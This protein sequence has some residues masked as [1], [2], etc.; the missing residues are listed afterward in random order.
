[1]TSVPGIG[2]KGAEILGMEKDGDSAI[3]NTYQLVGK[4][5]SLRGRGMT[6]KQHKDAFWFYLQARGLDA[7]RSVSAFLASFS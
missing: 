3:E 5:L 2:K 1:L 7:Y 6:S 4:Y